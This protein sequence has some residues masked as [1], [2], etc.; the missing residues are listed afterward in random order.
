MGGLK[1][2]EKP[3]IF[4]KRCYGSYA[5]FVIMALYN[6]PKAYLKEFT[7]GFNLIIKVEL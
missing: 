2:N 1:L 6:E 3:M 4:I 7:D 5:K